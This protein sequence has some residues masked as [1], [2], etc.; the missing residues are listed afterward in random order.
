MPK[1]SDRDTTDHGERDV[2]SIKIL[3]FFL[4][5]LGLLVLVGTFAAL[6][7][8]RGAIVNAISGL[9]LATVGAAMLFWAKRAGKRSS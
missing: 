2:A 4:T 5:V 1:P 8:P 3:G 9:V 7:N 6:E